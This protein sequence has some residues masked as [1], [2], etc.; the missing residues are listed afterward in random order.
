MKIVTNKSFV[1]NDSNCTF[2]RIQP[3]DLSITIKNILIQIAD[4]SWLNKIASDPLK[5][6]FS[7]NASA[8][9]LDL[10]AKF[11]NAADDS[12]IKSVS[13]EYIVSVLTKEAIIYYKNHI[14]VPLMELLGRKKTGNPGFDFYTED[15]EP[16]FLIFCG[17]AKYQN[18]SN[19]YGSS[20]KQIKEFIRDNKHVA[21]LTIIRDFVSEESQNNLIK[22]S[23]GV[24]SGFSSVSSTSDDSLIN[25]ISKNPNFVDL[26]SSCKN[27]LLVAV[28]LS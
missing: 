24:S 15:G 12:T 26:L 5:R 6:A 23:F 10:T 7:Q 21:D 9:L 28:D 8:T 20:I 4:L 14:D 11:N 22:N 13:G 19:A 18:N 25:N 3:G 2:I 1:L 27:I 17:E 16:N